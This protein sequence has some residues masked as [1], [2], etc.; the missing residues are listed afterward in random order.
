M[1]RSLTT[2]LAIAAI[3][4]VSSILPKPVE[5]AAVTLSGYAWSENT[6]WINFKGSN[7]GVTVDNSTGNFS[8]Y[9]WTENIGWLS[10]NAADVSG[11]PSGSCTPN[12]VIASGVVS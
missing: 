6:G 12:V 10:F 8:G 1:K 7:Y 2:I 11:C 4:V 9:A 5:A 3:V